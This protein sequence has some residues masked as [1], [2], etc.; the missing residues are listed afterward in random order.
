MRGG[1]PALTREAAPEPLAPW[2]RVEAALTLLAVDPVGLKGL[3][4]RA[5]AC[6]LR[7]RVT[8]ALSALPLPVRRIHPT[9]GDDALFGGLDLA[10][11]LSTGS[12]VIQKGILD[13]PAALVLAMA[14]RAMPGLAARLG[15]ALDEPRHCLIALDE[16][17]E[18]DELLPLGLVD[19][20]GLFVDIDGLQWG[21]TRD[22]SID[23]DRLAAA[24]ARLSSV[25]TPAKAGETLARVA[26]QVGIAS[27]RAPTL[28]LAAARAQAAWEDHETIT[29]DDLR[30]AADLVFGHRAMPASEE[31][32]P[33]PEPPEPP[34]DQPDDMPPPPEEQQ[35]DEMFPEEM[36]VEAVRAALPPDLLEQLAAGRAARMARG[37]TGTG[38]AKSGNRRGRP[39][40]SRM[41][42][43]GTGAR[44]DLVGTLRAAAPWQPLR[45]RQQQSDAVL[46]VRPSDIRL[47]RFRETSDRVLI[48]AVDASGSSAMA[49]LSEAKGAVELLLGQAYARRDHVSLLAFRGRDAELILPPTRSLVQTKRRLAGLPGGGGTPLA[50]GLQMAL[51]VGIQ[52]RA[53]GMTPT[54]ALLTDGRGNIALDGSANRAQA[55]ED[56]LKLASLLRASGLPAIVIDTA[57]R[58]QPSLA[59]LA[60]ALDAPYIALPRAD[61][62]KL[63]NVLGAAMGD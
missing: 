60:K 24:R 37:A 54:V 34:E 33:E 5:R 25:K 1:G 20:L 22:I 17:A 59:K 36:L 12:P 28:A 43:L 44:I 18:R 30:R 19:R 50:H 15:T 63:S 32:P 27:L 41:G 39:L 38:S 4:L 56:S 47:K 26:A 13:E 9:I 48:F 11:T 55:E 8:A 16:G 14:E 52:A 7:D 61:A 23:P 58:P 46:L 2:E 53:R 45:R 35:G 31:A 62:H 3:W 49:R 57:N 42:R 10:A 6:P 40:P 29:D 51:A 21:D